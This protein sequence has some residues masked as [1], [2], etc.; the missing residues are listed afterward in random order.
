MKK[1]VV[2]EETIE[3]R[4]RRAQGAEQSTWRC[5][6]AV[7][8]RCSVAVSARATCGR[9]LDRRC[10]CV[11]NGGQMLGDFTSS[12]ASDNAAALATALAATIAAALA[13]A[14]AVAAVVAVLGYAL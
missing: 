13:A 6:V 14:I 1:T 9:E 4:R 2:K 7:S 10:P 5:S 3:R 8:A 11:R 12:V